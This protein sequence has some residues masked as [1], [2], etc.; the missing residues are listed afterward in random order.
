MKNVQ[1]DDKS[2]QL[3][4]TLFVSSIVHYIPTKLPAV[5]NDSSENIHPIVLGAVG[6]NDNSAATRCAQVY[7]GSTTNGGAFAKRSTTKRLLRHLASLHVGD[8]VPEA[9]IRA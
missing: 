8:G 5:R 9:L 6:T 2:R 7:S 3:K 4:R 1:V